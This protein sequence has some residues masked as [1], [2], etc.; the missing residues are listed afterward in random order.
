MPFVSLEKKRALEK[1][2]EKL[3]ILES[4]FLEA[5]IHGSGKGG[6]KLNKT[7]SCVQLKHVPTGII[8][9]IQISRSREVN[10]F[11]ARREIVNAIDAQIHRRN[12]LKSKKIE[13]K[14]KQKAKRKKRTRAKYHTD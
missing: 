8:V 7:A 2:M 12:S 13:K 6:Q 4:D 14:R 9:K 10:R 11:L 1:D 5:F 3:G